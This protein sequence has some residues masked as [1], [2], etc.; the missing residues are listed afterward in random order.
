MGT[1]TYGGNESKES[2]RVSG[3][4]PLDTYR[5]RQQSMPASYQNPFPSSRSLGHEHV[6]RYCIPLLVKQPISTNKVHIWVSS[7]R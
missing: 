6:L 4:R 3:E 7:W 2:A 1:A 5:F